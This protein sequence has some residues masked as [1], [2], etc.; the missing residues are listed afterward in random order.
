MSARIRRYAR[1]L[2][3]AVLFV[4]FVSVI[5][6]RAAVGFVDYSGEKEAVPLAPYLE[7]LVDG[8]GRLDIERIF[9]QE[10]QA[11]FSPLSAGL[12]LNLRGT[13]WL[14]F[15]LP[16]APAGL[17]TPFLRLDLGTD[18]PA[19]AVLYMPDGNLNAALTT[20]IPQYPVEKNIFV[21]QLLGFSHQAQTPVTV[22]VKIPGAVGLWFAPQLLTTQDASLKDMSGASILEMLAVFWSWLLSP[23]SSL[24][25]VVLGAL[26]VWCLARAFR[27]GGE[28]RLW[29]AV[30]AVLALLE[31]MVPMPY[32]PAGKIPLQA[33][34]NVVVPGLCFILLIHVGR[35]LLYAKGRKPRRDGLLAPLALLGV[36]LPVLPLIP[37]LS[38]FL[39]LMPLWPLLSVLPALACLGAVVAKTPGAKRYVLSCLVLALGGGLAWLAIGEAD[40]SPAMVQAPLWAS[41]AFVFLVGVTYVREQPRQADA[42]E[43]VEILRFDDLVA[44]DETVEDLLAPLARGSVADDNQPAESALVF[45]PSPS[46][47]AVREDVESEPPAGDFGLLSMGGGKAGFAES[48]GGLEDNRQEYKEPK[49]GRLSLK[50][51]PKLAAMDIPAKMPEPAAGP[52]EVA[53]ED[54]PLIELRDIVSDSEARFEPGGDA[55]PEPAPEPEPSIVAEPAPESA[56]EPEL[57]AVEEYPAPAEEPA[58]LVAAAPD[59]VGEPEPAVRSDEADE[60]GESGEVYT[61]EEVEET[62]SS[63]PPWRRPVGGARK[64]IELVGDLIRHGDADDQAE[65]AHKEPVLVGPDLLKGQRAAAQWSGR[66]QE[67]L[68]E[69]PAPV[70]EA[71]QVVADNDIAAADAAAENILPDSGPEFEEAAATAASRASGIDFEDMVDETAHADALW[72]GEPAAGP[73]D[74][75]PAA[76]AEND[77]ALIRADDWKLSDMGHHGLAPQ[78]EVLPSR[79]DTVAARHAAGSEAGKADGDVSAAQNLVTAEAELEASLAALQGLLDSPGSNAQDLYQAFREQSRAIL[80]AGH[81]I[82]EQARQTPVSGQ[83]EF[84]DPLQDDL[85]EDSGGE[86][87]EEVFDLQLVLTNAHEAVRG[88][89]ERKNL[90]LS[91]FMPP[92]LPLLYLGEPARLQEVLRQLLDSAVA[93]TSKGTVQLAVRR[94]PDSTDPGH[95]I[96]SVSDSAL[97]EGAARRN[98]LALKR[99]WSLAAASGGGLNVESAPGQGSTV[100]FTMRLKRPADDLYGSLPGLDGDPAML[101]LHAGGTEQ[102]SIVSRQENHVLV[103]DEQATNRQLIAFFL[104]NLPYRV[105]EAKNLDEAMAIYAQRPTGLVVLDSQLEGLVV[106]EALRRLHGVDNSLKLSPVPVVAL[107]QDHDEITAMLSA[108]CKGTLRKPLSRKRVRDLVQTLLPR[109]DALDAEEAAA[110]MNS[111]RDAEFAEQSDELKEPVKGSPEDYV[112]HLEFD[113]LEEDDENGGPVAEEAPTPDDLNAAA[114]DNRSPAEPERGRSPARE[115]DKNIMESLDFLHFGTSALRTEAESAAAAEPVAGKFDSVQS[116]RARQEKDKPSAAAGGRNRWLSGFLD[117]AGKVAGAVQT[118]PRKKEAAQE[119]FEPVPLDAQSLKAASPEQL[120]RV[121]EVLEELDGALWAAKEGLAEENSLMVS[122]ACLALAEIAERHNLKNLE[123]IAQCVDRAAQANDLEAVHDLLSELEASVGRNRRQVEAALDDRGVM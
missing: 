83:A 33:L 68:E 35:H 59:L 66:A 21:L 8:S 100:A 84:A 73:E 104:G 38:G 69:A 94:V 110:S 60:P 112:S 31:G 24:V 121:P 58:V 42:E 5:P 90:A 36:L 17:E 55:A 114:P 91:W 93:A 22:Y 10:N 6:A 115:P 53:A 65:L 61:S 79:A 97:G 117:A 14:R 78:E 51:V 18:A 7:Y 63:T 96:F 71:L 86:A 29:T 54:E 74:R 56:S 89:A 82:V 88:E 46:P 81:K 26:T 80:A 52:R 23:S 48:P 101:H 1:T 12:P 116:E 102:L 39:R 119:T 16:P 4:L 99:A 111:V 57:A 64:G 15:T 75:A 43:G 32:A 85:L 76:S 106:S 45:P 27:R 98:P 105:V 103:V 11:R 13:V 20:W 108:G 47:A 30:F 28:W 70:A 49:G 67:V 109:E 123:R 37:G 2:V 3:P 34:L 107:I 118:A 41:A 113:I 40:P 19:G 87:R 95:L 92:H 120:E 50:L 72:S 25:Y 77:P 62:E 9:T 122:R 44:E